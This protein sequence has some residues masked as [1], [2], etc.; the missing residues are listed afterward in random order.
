[1]KAAVAT[2][3]L[4]AAGTEQQGL[5]GQFVGGDEGGNGSRETEARASSVPGVLR[6]H[7]GAEAIMRG[8]GWS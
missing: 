6:Q 8:H 5:G 1:M 3:E 4:K 7:E 2:V